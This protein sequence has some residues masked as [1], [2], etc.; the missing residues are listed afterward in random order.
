[1]I[2]GDGQGEIN[3]RSIIGYISIATH[4]LAFYFVPYLTGSAIDWK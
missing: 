1:M 2:K 3:F 4:N